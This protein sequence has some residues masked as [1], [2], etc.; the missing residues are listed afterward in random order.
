MHRHRDRH[1]RRHQGHHARR[2]RGH[3]QGRHARRRP[4]G[5]VG[6]AS[7]PGWAGA[8]SSRATAGCRMAHR[9][10]RHRR[11]GQEPA[12]SHRAGPHAR[13]LARPGRPAVGRVRGAQAERQRR[14]RTDC[15]P[16]VAREDLAWATDAWAARPGRHPACCHPA[17]CRSAGWCQS[18][19]CSA[20]PRA[21][22]GAAAS[23]GPARASARAWG[24]PGVVPRSPPSPL[25]AR[26]RPALPA[27]TALPASEVPAPAWQ[28]A[29][30]R[31]SVPP[32]G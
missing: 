9:H 19:G 26:V 15:Y 4:D 1:A 27:W 13:H 2:H 22:A 3:R 31:R 24:L 5:P 10:R 29:S 18:A 23:G 12:G 11:G 7:C 17:G 14:R 8:A 30:G 21:A 6:A 25:P 16:L 32:V 28:P 20:R